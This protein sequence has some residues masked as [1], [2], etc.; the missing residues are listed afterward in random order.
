[1]SKI[2]KRILIIAAALL[3]IYILYNLV[4]IIL[5]ICLVQKPMPITNPP[6][7]LVNLEKVIQ[8]EVQDEARFDPIPEYEI[9]N[10][11]ANIYI[12]IYIKND[13]INSSEKNLNNYVKTISKRVNNTL[14]DKKC[15]KN[16]IIDAVSA[17]ANNLDKKSHR[18]VF[19]IE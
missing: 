17:N 9:E 15:F 2:L 16:I 13:T 6:K 4:L 1:M 12:Y 7:E 8:K 11:N 19:P 18:F 10:C 5:A 14:Q 3:S